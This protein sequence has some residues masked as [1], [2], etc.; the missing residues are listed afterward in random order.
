MKCKHIKK[1]GRTCKANAM[2]GAPYCYTHNPEIDLTEKREARSRGGKANIIRLP[3]ENA[4]PGIS[5]DSTADIKTLIVDT[6]NRVRTGSMDIRIANC[7]GFL[8]G[9]LIR[10]FELS[11]LEN[12]IITLENQVLKQAD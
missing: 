5:I 3:V 4:A 8:S 12:R 6:I 2:A 9:H 11:E 10:A 7:I 1:N